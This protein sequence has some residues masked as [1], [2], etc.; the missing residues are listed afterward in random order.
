MLN[1]LWAGM[2]LI[3]IVYGAFQGT[4]PEMTD[5]IIESSKEAVSL[6]LTMVGIMSFWTGLM[7]VAEKAGLMERMASFFHP[8]VRFLFPKIPKGHKSNEHITTNIIAN[9]LGLGWAATPAGL[10]AMEALQELNEERGHDKS[11]AS[12]EMCTFLILNIS[13]LQLIPMTIIAYRSQYGSV[14]PACIVGPGLLATA[15]STIAAIAFCKMIQFAG[16]GKV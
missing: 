15:I 11:V 7:E 4:M 1:Y 14:D 6:C 2:I 16:R 12:D 5:V 9:M 13:S 10:R 3:G 8:F